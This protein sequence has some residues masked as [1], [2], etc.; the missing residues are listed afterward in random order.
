MADQSEL[1]F[2]DQLKG[3]I[4]ENI[5]KYP[6]A[7]EWMM[8]EARKISPKTRDTR[9]ERFI[10]EL[11]GNNLFDGHPFVPTDVGSYGVPGSATTNTTFIP[12]IKWYRSKHGTGLKESKRDCEEFIF[13]TFPDCVKA[14]Q[15]AN[16]EH[17]NPNGFYHVNGQRSY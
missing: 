10:K 12:L 14:R 8:E 4:D 11:E 17:W 13:F 6:D 2:K 5:D 16:S 7:I 1:S 3:L 15:L 9:Y